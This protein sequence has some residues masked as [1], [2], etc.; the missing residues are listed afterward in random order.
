M[1]CAA[2]GWAGEVEANERV[3]GKG[4][5][6]DRR[7]KKRETS[8]RRCVRTCGWSRVPGVENRAA[9]Q[10]NTGGVADKLAAANLGRRTNAEKYIER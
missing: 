1:A 6:S 5:E 8:R 7:E 10:H 3:S 2:N 9:H 4:K